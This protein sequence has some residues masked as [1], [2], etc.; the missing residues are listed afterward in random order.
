MTKAPNMYVRDGESYLT[1]DSIDR[2]VGSICSIVQPSRIAYTRMTAS[3]RANEP[4]MLVESERRDKD[5]AVRVC[6]AD[7]CLLIRTLHFFFR[8]RGLG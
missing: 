5:R 2:S 6:R 7:N 8:V 1:T 4:G 3:E